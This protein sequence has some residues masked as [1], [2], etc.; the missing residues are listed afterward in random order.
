MSPQ[1]WGEIYFIE[2]QILHNYILRDI[3][4]SKG[5]NQGGGGGGGQ[6]TKRNSKRIAK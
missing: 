6:T 3:R 4:V 2:L 1:K 5:Q